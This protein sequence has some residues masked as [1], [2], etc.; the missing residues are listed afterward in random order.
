MDQ[1]NIL[2][3]YEKYLNE[4]A[5]IQLQHNLAF[6]NN[7]LSNVEKNKEQILSQPLSHPYTQIINS[8]KSKYNVV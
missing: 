2:S 7:I 8:G 4:S 3:C 1:S 5:D 6:I